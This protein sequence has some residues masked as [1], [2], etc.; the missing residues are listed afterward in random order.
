MPMR[1]LVVVFLTASGVLLLSGATL[2]STANDVLAEDDRRRKGRRRLAPHESVHRYLSEQNAMG[3]MHPN[4]ALAS[5]ATADDG[6]TEFEYDVDVVQATPAINSRTT[7]SRYGG[8]SLV[9]PDE[10]LETKFLVQD[11]KFG[12]EVEV[13]S[14]EEA[15][16]SHTANTSST[17]FAL[18]AVHEFELNGITKKAGQKPMNILLEP[19]SKHMVAQESDEFIPPKDFRCQVDSSLGRRLDEDQHSHHDHSHSHSHSHD[20]DVHDPFS[21][22][23]ESLIDGLTNN[24]HRRRTA[25][26]SSTKPS[27]QVD[28][29][30]EI[31]PAF[32]ALHDNNEANA[33]KYLNAVV[34][35]A[36]S[37]MQYEFDLKLNVKHIDLNENYVSADDA[38]GALALM[39]DKYA[40]SEW[41]HEDI[42]LH[43]AILGN[44]MGGGVAYIG[45]LCSSRYGFGIRCVVFAA[46][47]SSLIPI[48]DLDSRQS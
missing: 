25:G 40:A 19:E 2:T 17:A 15:D 30:L 46:L 37:I 36:S 47:F 23:V 28:L 4:F 22:G 43:H 21:G 14:A 6:V 26:F 27:F 16:N 20:S 41:H 1:G 44:Q 18:V 10:V 34:T 45:A 12:G 31:D 3:V 35:A 38:F 11:K 32:I 24:Q 9:I 8:P 7:Y 33:L 42:D 13:E 48:S 29:Y 39:R 5:Y